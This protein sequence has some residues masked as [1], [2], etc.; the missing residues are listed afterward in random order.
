MWTLSMDSWKLYSMGD[1]VRL[2]DD[3]GMPYLRQNLADGV[4]IRVVS[5]PQL[6]CSAPGHNGR[7]VI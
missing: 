1:L 7:F 2:L 3:D 4:E 6:G 5:R